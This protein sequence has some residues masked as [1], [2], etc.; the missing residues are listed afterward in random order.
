M[1]NNRVYIGEAVHKGAAFPGE[2]S[3][4]VDRSLW[5]RVHA[6]L[7][8]EPSQRGAQAKSEHPLSLKGI[9]FL[10]EGQR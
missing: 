10:P 2:A 1:L 6:V 8:G 4:I 3:G 5:E 9:L 7:Q